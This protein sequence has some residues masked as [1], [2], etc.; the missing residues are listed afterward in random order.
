M[1]SI[2][3]L[4]YVFIISGGQHQG[5]TTYVTD[6]V[7][8][9]SENGYKTGGFVAPGIFE[10]NH[11]VSFQIMD[12]KTGITMPLCSLNESSGERVGPFSFSEEGLNFGKQLLSAENLLECDF[13]VID[14]V[15][16]FELKGKG[17]SSSIE[18]LMQ[19][20][21]HFKMIWV[22]RKPVIEKVLKKFRVKDFNLIDI[23]TVSVADALEILTGHS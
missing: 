2:Y 16:P 5:K 10:N 4:P 7:K 6:L 9:L 22:V 3:S 12:L 1:N 8:L 14:E 13:V 21:G 15:G 20:G 11:R 17:W 18:K 19:S 23:S